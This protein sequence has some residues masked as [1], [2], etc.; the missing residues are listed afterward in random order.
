MRWLWLEKTESHWPWGMFPIQVGDGK[1]TFLEDRWLHGQ[2]IIDIAPC[3]PWWSREIS[4]KER[5]QKL[6][7]NTYGFQM[8]EELRQLEL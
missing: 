2:H 1:H 8:H 5:W 7:M 3:T 4:R 6:S